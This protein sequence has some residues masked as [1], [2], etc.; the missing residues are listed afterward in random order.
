QGR[1]KNL[2]VAATGTGKT[3][4]AAFD[5]RAICQ[6]QGGKPRLLFVAH[7]SEIL[8][9]ALRTY[10]EVLRDASFGDLLGG[11]HEPDSFEHLFTT[12]DSL[13]SR[14]L[15]EKQGADYWYTVVVDECHHLAAQRFDQ[16][17]KAVK[18][19][20]LVGLTATPERSDG[21]PIQSYFDNRPDGSPAVE[22]RLWQALDLQL[23]TPFEY[24]ACD[25]ATDFS[26]VP[27]QQ[28]GEQQALDNLVTGNDV[29]ARLVINEWRRLT[30]NPRA[31]KALIFCVS[32]AHAEFMTSKLNAAG[33]PAECI[34]SSTASDQRRLAP[35]RLVSGELCALVTVDLYNEG[36]D[37]PWV[38]TLLLLRP[39][40]SPVVFQQQIGRGL[41]LSDGKQTCLVLDFVGQHRKEFRFDKLL[42]SLTG[43]TRRELIHSVENGFASLPSGCFIQLYKH[44]REQILQ[45]LRSLTQQSWRHLIRELQT[46]AALHKRQTV[47]LG[48]LLHEQVL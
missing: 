18:P 27:W 35:Q 7:R 26:Q 3:V 47:K 48:E 29:R 5:Y 45:S 23:L 33:L 11:G 32:I 4:V 40:Q 38:D 43:Q 30:A 31:C 17:I 9:Q 21:Q 6:Q 12:I 8:Q 19:A 20:I 22:L 34:V 13:S 2:I 42:T 10:R 41:R 46:F 16:F 25:D 28:A 14:K 36:I 37:L 44:T 39:T 1:F 15:M 24:F